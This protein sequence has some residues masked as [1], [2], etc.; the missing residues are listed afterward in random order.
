MDLLTN[1]CEFL[2]KSITGLSPS[3]SRIIVLFL[4]L[5]ILFYF[6]LVVLSLTFLQDADRSQVAIGIYP[7]G[8]VEKLLTFLL[9][10]NIVPKSMDSVFSLS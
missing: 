3:F 9:L 2:P 7:R 5:F 4:F 6:I 10:V 1:R 8:C